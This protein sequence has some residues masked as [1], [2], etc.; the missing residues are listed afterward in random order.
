MSFSLWFMS[1]FFSCMLFRGGGAVDKLFTF[2]WPIQQADPA[3]GQQEPTGHHCNPSVSCPAHQCGGYSWNVKSCHTWFILL[4]QCYILMF[5][6][7]NEREQIM[8]TNCWLTQV[9]AVELLCLCCIFFKI[10][11]FLRR[12]SFAGMEWLPF[13]VGSRGVWRDQKN[14]PSFPAYMA[15][16]HCP[17]QQV[18]N[19]ST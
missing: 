6:F 10:K 16:W 12:V 18:R 7:Q 2:P 15:T 9:W 19:L 1:V 8:T 14:S 17:V 11:V 3:S 13:D 4:Y 5:V